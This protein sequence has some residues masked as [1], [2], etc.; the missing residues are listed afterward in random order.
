VP[1]TRPRSMGSEYREPRGDASRPR[2][3][4]PLLEERQAAGPEPAG[5]RSG[6]VPNGRRSGS[7][8]GAAWSA[9][10]QAGSGEERGGNGAK[11]RMPWYGRTPHRYRAGLAEL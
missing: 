1:A 7:A 4:A 6:G 10:P 8:A 11:V 3:C 9:L 5:S 2:L